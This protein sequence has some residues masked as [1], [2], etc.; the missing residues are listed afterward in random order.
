MKKP[1]PITLTLELVDRG[2]RCPNRGIPLV[3]L[4]LMGEGG[5]GQIGLGCWLQAHGMS[6]PM[7]GIVAEW[8]KEHGVKIAHE[9]VSTDAEHSRDLFTGVE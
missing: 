7:A 6:V 4:Y 5:K 9:E 2:E 8:F 3:D 1:P